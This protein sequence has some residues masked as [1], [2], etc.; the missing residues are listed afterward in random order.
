MNVG[1]RCY[2]RAR[3][4]TD[5][6]YR[7][8]TYSSDDGMSGYTHMVLGK[9]VKINK[10]ISHGCEYAFLPDDKTNWE[11]PIYGQWETHIDNLSAI[12][13]LRIGDSIPD[14]VRAPAQVSACLSC[15]ECGTFAPMAEVNCKDN[16]FVCYSCRDTKGWKFKGILL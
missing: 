6:R 9:I 16:T 12:G 14:T 5:G 11:Y 8:A 7:L 15:R 2:C 1:D 4:L 3:I 13:N 10:G